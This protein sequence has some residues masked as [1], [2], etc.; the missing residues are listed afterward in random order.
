[1]TAELK[2]LQSYLERNIPISAALGAK[3]LEIGT[4][5]L[6]VGA[7]LGA[8]INHKLTVFG[9]SLQAVATLACWSLLHHKLRGEA[10]P[11]EIVIM[12]STID[13]TKPVTGD[14]VA[15]AFLPHDKSW[16]QFIRTFERRGKARV[17]LT[18]QIYQGEELAV[19]YTGTFAAL[20][21]S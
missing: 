2:H 11:G 14:F 3:V 8:N 19:D 9:G 17:Q 21:T 16:Q 6:S 12:N 10:D 18:A 5:T 15:T 13:Y 1:M 20:K 4:D 7:P